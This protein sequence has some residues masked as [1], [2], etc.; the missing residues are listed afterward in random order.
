M[1]SMASLSACR[2]CATLRRG[3]PIPA[4]PSQNAPAPIPSS[5]RPPLS[6]SMVAACLAS[7]AGGRSG[8][9]A[10]LVNK[11]SWLVRAASQVMWARASV[12]PGL[13]G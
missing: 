1:M 10:T 4:I 3:P 5:N 11:R 12:N 7:T 6:R 13:Y 2:A 8:R 9:L